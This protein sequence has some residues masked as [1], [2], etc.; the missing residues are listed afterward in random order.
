MAA[1][2]FLAAVRNE[3]SANIF[4]STSAD[5]IHNGRSFF[6]NTEEKRPS[7]RPLWNAYFDGALRRIVSSN[8]HFW[9]SFA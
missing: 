8:K 3:S 9:F 4:Q 5:E 2:L 6:V 1:T 7:I